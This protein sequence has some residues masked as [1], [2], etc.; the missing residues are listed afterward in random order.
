MEGVAGAKAGDPLRLAVFSVWHAKNLFNLYLLQCDEAFVRASVW[1]GTPHSMIVK[2]QQ[3]EINL[4]GLR[5]L[6]VSYRWSSLCFDGGGRCR[7]S[8]VRR[9]GRLVPCWF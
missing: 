2:Q 6:H 3:S 8:Q 7:W 5:S 1:S 9:K 4:C